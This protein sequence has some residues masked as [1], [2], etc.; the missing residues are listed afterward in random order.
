MQLTEHPKQHVQT[1]KI[2]WPRPFISA[3]VI[4]FLLI[5]Y[6]NT[7]RSQHVWM[8]KVLHCQLLLF[9]PTLLV[10][11][12]NSLGSSSTVMFKLFRASIIQFVTEEGKGPSIDSTNGTS[13]SSTVSG[14][15][16]R[17][18]Y[19]TE[20]VLSKATVVSDTFK[21]DAISTRMSFPIQYI[22]QHTQNIHFERT[23]SKLYGKLRQIIM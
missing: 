17:L 7:S 14:G 3:F 2:A 5:T 11:C 6:L 19:L 18:M 21:T 4:H 12:S 20:L 10:P 9:R 23:S 22:V 8:T 1:R 15:A 13:S 16:G